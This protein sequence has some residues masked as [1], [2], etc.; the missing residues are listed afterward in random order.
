MLEQLFKL[1][2]PL[3]YAML[4]LNDRPIILNAHEWEKLQDIIP[5]FKPFEVRTTELSGKDY[6]TLTIN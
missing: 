5:I 3:T 4:S 6:L 1:K 2:E